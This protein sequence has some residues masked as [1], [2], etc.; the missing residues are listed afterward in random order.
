M[1]LL[2]PK[3]T[4][5]KGAFGRLGHAGWPLRARGNL[6]SP[7]WTT[8]AVR[9]GHE[10]CVT[11]FCAMSEPKTM[12]V[13]KSSAIGNVHRSLAHTSCKNRR[14]Y[15]LPWAHA[16]RPSSVYPRK[17]DVT[18]SRCPTATAPPICQEACVRDGF[19]FVWLGLFPAVTW[20]PN[21]NIWLPPPLWV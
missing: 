17:F 7:I 18:D 14:Q 9:H 20:A 13:Q 8:Q 4:W 2:H 16:Y 15:L 21:L 19:K 10:I 6:I 5:S 3:S 12:R 11:Q 1:T